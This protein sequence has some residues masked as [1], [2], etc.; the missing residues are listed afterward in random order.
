MAHLKQCDVRSWRAVQ[1]TLKGHLETPFPALVAKPAADV[2][3][4]ELVTVIRRPLQDGKMTTARKLRAYLHAA[5]SC[6]VR[7]DSDPSLPSSFT[8]FNVTRNPVETV[9][10]IKGRA[11]KRPLPVADLRRYW[12]QLKE[13]DGPAGAALRLH[14]LSGGQRPQQLARIT[15]NDIKD[16]VLR[17]MDGKGRRTAAR[18]HLLPITDAMQSELAT[19]LEVVKEVDRRQEASNEKP[20]AGFLLSTDGGKT[21]MHSSSLSN[22]A[23]EIGADAGIADFQLKRVRSGIETLLAAARIPKHVRGQLQSHGIGG[24]QDTHYDDHDYIEEKREAL[25]ELQR[26]LE[27]PSL[28]TANA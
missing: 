4:K 14:V 17:L 2:D 26:L 27:S 9:A 22:W 24:V 12:N 15:E 5:Y 10:P 20:T 7:A 23:S 1:L 8:A 11:D 25:A 18:A 28:V 19:L 6:A 13:R 21:S 16:G 3:K